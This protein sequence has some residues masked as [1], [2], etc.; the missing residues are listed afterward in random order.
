[1]P[2]TPDDKNWTWI[3]ERPCPECGFVASDLARA[4]IGRMIRDNAAAW[5]VVLARPDVAVR[6]NDHTWSAL[7]YGCHVRDVYR[8]CAGR[9]DLM[10]DED[11]PTFANWDQDATATQ[12][13]YAGQEPVRVARELVEAAARIAARFDHVSGEQWDR[14]GTRSDGARFT[15]ESFGRYVVHD[16][17]HHL[18]DVG[19]NGRA[20]GK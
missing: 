20:A 10:L 6:P 17:V 5:P 3:L 8:I 11:D 13:D 1:M 15:V 4:D 19:I 16:P 14:P 7:E 12:D 18:V 2:I 9:L